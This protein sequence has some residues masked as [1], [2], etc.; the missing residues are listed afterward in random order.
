MDTAKAKEIVERM[1][2]IDTEARKIEDPVKRIEFL[3]E[4]LA[5]LNKE[6]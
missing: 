5:K 4:E 1:N 3:N 2:E 6:A